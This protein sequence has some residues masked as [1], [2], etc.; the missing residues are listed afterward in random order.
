MT[1]IASQLQPSAAVDANPWW[2]YGH[3]WLLI[4]LLTFAV[5]ASCGLLY[6]ALRISQTDRI[7]ADPIH[8]R[9]DAPAKVTQPNMLPAEEA[10]HH[11]A[12]GGAGA[13]SLVKPAPAPV[14][15]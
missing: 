13:P 11:A 5:A 4:G 12:T 14:D 8:Q 1:M 2:R 15:D 9:N 6:A 7:Y 10:S 3:V